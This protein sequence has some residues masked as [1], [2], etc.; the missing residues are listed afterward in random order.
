M[1]QEAKA[2]VE[3]FADVLVTASRKAEKLIREME[4]MAGAYGDLGLS[5]LRV[6]NYEDKE[7]ENVGAYSPMGSAARSL[8]ADLR[9][10]GMSTVKMS[11]LTRAATG[12]CVGSLETVHEE[13]AMAPVAVD[14]LNER[15]AALLTVRSLK[16]DAE[17]RRINVEA[18]ENGGGAPGDQAKARK[19]QNLRNEIASLEAAIEAAEMEYV[20]VKE[21]NEVELDRW[22]SGRSKRF[23][24]MA[25]RVG[26]LEATYYERVS[27]LCSALSKDLL[28]DSS[29]T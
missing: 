16:D 9:R 10:V 5:L 2:G 29:N 24:S 4:R 19:V 14:A 27:E 21:R 28:D 1:S 8:S 26:S 17:K 13:L 20:K 6:S 3:S 23:V 15:E 12:E 25:N 22:R 18:L 11:R 7:A